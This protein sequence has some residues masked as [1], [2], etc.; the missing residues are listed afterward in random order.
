HIPFNPLASIYLLSTVQPTF[1]P[2]T[3]QHALVPTTTPV[4]DHVRTRLA[5]L[6][7]L[8]CCCYSNLSCS[9]YSCSCHRL[10]QLPCQSSFSHLPGWA[11]PAR[12]HMSVMR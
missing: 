3:G 9:S 11:T 4:H 6:P 8:R 12:R 5:L 7:A 10:R 1:S 2:H